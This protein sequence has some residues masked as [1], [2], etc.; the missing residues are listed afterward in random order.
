MVITVVVIA[1]ALFGLRSMA[2]GVGAL[3]MRDLPNTR[4]VGEILW[5]DEVLTMS[6]RL[7]AATGEPRWVRR[8]RAH[9]PRLSAALAESAR[10]APD[11]YSATATSRTNEA[12]DALVRM[13]TRSFELLDSGRR[14]QAS[15]LLDS[16]EYH[17]QKRIYAEGMDAA[18]R[19]I[20]DAISDHADDLGEQV[21][22][23]VGVAWL[24]L[25]LLGST[26]AFVFLGVR[27]LFSAQTDAVRCLD[28]AREMAES[29][30][31]AKSRF[32]ANMS[33]EIRT[34]LNGVLGMN[35]LMLTTGLDSEQRQFCESI[36][37]SGETLKHVIDDILDLSKIE[38]GKLSLESIPFDLQAHLEEV[39]LLVAPRLATGRVELLVDVSERLPRR[40]TG[41]PKRLGQVLL[42]LAGNAAKFTEQGEVRLRAVLA[43]SAEVADDAGTVWIDFEVVDTGLGIPPERIA[44]L[45]S[46]FEQADASTTRRFGGTGL[47]L[48]ISQRLV[49]SLG[50]EL[51][52]ESEPGVGSRFV[53]RLPFAIDETGEP[54]ASPDAERSEGQFAGRRA[55]VVDDH[56]EVRSGLRAHLAT[57]GF[58]AEEAAD[59]A[60]A[61]A[62]V[63]DIERPRIDVVLLDLDMPG[64]SGPESA[65]ALRRRAGSRSVG[66][67]ELPDDGVRLIGVGYDL[68]RF[69]D[70]GL[71]GRLLKPV[72]LTNLVGALEAALSLA[73]DSV[74]S[75]GS[76]DSE[77][78][79]LLQ[80]LRPAVLIAEDNRVNQRVIAAMLQ[81]AGVRCEFADD[82]I[83]AV[84]AASTWRYNAIL[85]DCQMPAL[86]G[87]DA[88][89]RI[90]DLEQAASRPRTPVLALTANVLAG[91]RERCVA[92]GMDDYLTKPI[93]AEPLYAALVAS[94]QSHALI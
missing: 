89:R 8:Y 39:G 37:F 52:V 92:A 22:S 23:A 42:N 58:E 24:A 82:G 62:R 67:S 88:T 4:L 34:P 70:D 80:E 85:M 16:R 36:R 61:L 20:L 21:E 65:D 3:A 44:R 18:Q 55:L 19:S 56:A 54:E 33:H 30:M 2:S 46:A 59:G 51:S 83:A 48:A 25:A 5:L 60:S 90:R 81:R 75:S 91:E 86:D 7:A 13:E 50:G 15:A 32:L 10:L 74:P 6:S 76:L 69:P 9:E 68:A 57:L 64:W 27:R 84:S 1:A 73:P 45:F 79:R 93:S 12:N 63:S 31:H 40:I 66:G 87:Y 11:A 28:R 72:R 43:D 29:A 35:E 17:E 47:G 77:N 71:D 14:E 41:D 53:A 94:L 26:W 38:A 49:R 78:R